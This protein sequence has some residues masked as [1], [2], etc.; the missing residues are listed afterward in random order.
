MYDFG[1]KRIYYKVYIVLNIRDSLRID[2]FFVSLL[3]IM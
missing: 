2:L 1:I 3:P